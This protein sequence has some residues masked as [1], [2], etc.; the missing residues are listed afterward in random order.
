[1]VL[2]LYFAWNWATS[3]PPSLRAAAVIGMF[4]VNLN[5]I[6]NL[7]LGRL[8]ENYQ[9]ALDAYSGDI[10]NKTLLENV[11]KTGKKYIYATVFF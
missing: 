7:I 2:F 8:N 11:W 9:Q 1:M 4:L 6:Y 3:I 10:G 5:M